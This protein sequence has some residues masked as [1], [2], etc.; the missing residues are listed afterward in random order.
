VLEN[1]QEFK[2]IMCWKIDIVGWNLETAGEQH[3]AKWQ[4]ERN[5]CPQVNGLSMRINQ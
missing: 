3:N 1:Y 5:R 2:T 4:L